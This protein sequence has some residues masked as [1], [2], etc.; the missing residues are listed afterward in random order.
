M[1][2][3]HNKK[4][5]NHNET[6]K[7]PEIDRR[8][9]KLEHYVRETS[10]NHNRKRKDTGDKGMICRG[11][12][13]CSPEYIEWMG[14]LSSMGD[15]VPCPIGFDETKEVSLQPR[16]RVS[17]TREASACVFVGASGY[18][19]LVVSPGD[20][21]TG[22]G[23]GLQPGS[24]LGTF[25]TVTTTGSVPSTMTAQ[26]SI[27]A[28]DGI[29]RT[30]AYNAAPG[31]NPSYRFTGGKFEI[32]GTPKGSADS[33][34]TYS[35][36]AIAGGKN[37]SLNTNNIVNSMVLPQASDELADD[38]FDGDG[39]VVPI[40]PIASPDGYNSSIDQVQ[41][42][43]AV[44][45]NSIIADG[46]WLFFRGAPGTCIDVEVCLSYDVF[47]V[48]EK[49]TGH[50]PIA[51]LSETYRG[52]LRSMAHTL[53][54]PLGKNLV[55]NGQAP[56][57]FI[58]GLTFNMLRRSSHLIRDLALQPKAGE[59]SEGILTKMAKTVSSVFHVAKI[60]L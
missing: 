13:C 22:K 8:L 5:N 1:S 55:K 43:P 44:A 31:L 29:G 47:V 34:V 10:S 28:D 51:S 15:V 30:F 36:K 48:G 35:V 11:Q 40:F 18:G 12:K 27:T 20:F 45:V 17:I 57:G 9:S 7:I 54:R 14:S 59:D 32:Q 33:A 3:N 21:L 53:S 4:N 41:H 26:A 23:R 2:K 38:I 24:V 52:D 56:K 25:T 50:D 58:T 60:F 39:C 19:Y 42:L 6:R 16:V 37:W 49:P 46:R